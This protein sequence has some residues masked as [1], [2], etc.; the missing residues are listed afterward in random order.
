MKTRSQ[1]KGESSQPRAE[2]SADIVGEEPSAPL[3]TTGA[4]LSFI[5]GSTTSSSTVR[6][7][8]VAAQ[9]EHAKKLLDL[10]RAAAAREAE[11]ERQLQQRERESPN[12]HIF[13]LQVLLMRCWLNHR[14][15]VVTSVLREQ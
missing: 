11:R 14:H 4:A 1:T 10:E 7:R 3:E 13:N 15:S 6:A 12:L 8:S 9:V 2:S 5:S